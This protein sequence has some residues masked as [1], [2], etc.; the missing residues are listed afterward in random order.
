MFCYLLPTWGLHYTLKQNAPETSGDWAMC[1][2]PANYYWGGTWLGAY[3]GTKNPDLA[4]EFIKYLNTDDGFLTE[5]AKATGDVMG[6]LNVQNA[7]KDTYSDE[8]LGGQNHYAAFC[9]MAKGIDGSL[10]QGTDQQIE[11]LFNEATAAYANG[12]KT[13]EEALAEFR[14]QVASTMGY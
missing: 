4:K 3:K 12:E 1:Q 13:K 8:F 9:E 5:W 6:N 10:V 7:L 11:A 2:G 14:D